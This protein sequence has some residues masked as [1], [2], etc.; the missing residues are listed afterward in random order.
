MFRSTAISTILLT[1]LL[2]CSCANPA[3]NQPKAVTTNAAPT[4]PTA[5]SAP[6]EKYRITPETSKITFVGSKVTD[7][8]DGTW[9]YE[10]AIYNA[11]NN[12]AAK[13]F[14]L[15]IHCKTS[16]TNTGFHDG[17]YHSVENYSG[18]DWTINNGLGTMRF[19]TQNASENPNANALRWSTLY[20]FRFTTD[21][22]PTNKTGSIE[23][24]KAT[25]GGAPGIL[26]FTVAGPSDPACLANWNHDKVT[27]ST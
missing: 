11:N 1:A 20:N 27:N 4:A 24:F 18:T 21:T 22:P 5:P 9:N 17:V 25:G 2:V 13:G 14:S 19:F 16:V 26:T 3:T 8:G 7:N 6:G 10:Y 23:L 12:R 15:P